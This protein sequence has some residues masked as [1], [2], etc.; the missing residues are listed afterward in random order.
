MNARLVFLTSIFLLAGS[1][2][3]QQDPGA[4]PANA[5]F[6]QPELDQMLAPV[7]L[8]P[9]PM[10]TE[11]LTA[12]TYPLEIVEAARWSQA[13]PDLNGTDAVDA[14]EGRNWDPSVKALLAFPDLLQTMSDRIDWTQDLGDAFLGQQAQVMDTVQALR[15]RA[16]ASGNLQSGGE[17]RV[18]SDD[19]IVDIEP[20][21]PD[22][23]YLPYYDPTVVYGAWWWPDYPPVCWMPWPGYYFQGAFGYGV[24]VALG[25]GF[26]HD[27]FDWH[28]HRVD[29]YA[30]GRPWHRGAGVAQG[31]EPHVWRHDPTHR[32]S[33]AYRNPDA[34]QRFDRDRDGVRAAAPPALRGDDRRAPPQAIAPVAR[35]PSDVLNERM[36]RSYAAPPMQR[37]EAPSEDT[38]RVMQSRGGFGGGAH[39]GAARAP[40]RGGG[41]FAGHH[42]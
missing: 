22:L 5:T 1:A 25:A 27:D 31:G 32:R 30:H 40:A 29:V 6:S 17:L 11:V 35:I 26:F 19:G 18:D 15:Q 41:S 4:S 28:H 39:M 12:A 24:G 8:Y 2:F 7:A 10:L 9:D 21:A 13:N 34:G 16:E 33:V 14:A 38:G 36:P 3:A 20:A 42:R 23:V 37:A